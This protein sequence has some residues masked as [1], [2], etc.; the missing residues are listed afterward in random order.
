M[1][2]AAVFVLTGA[3][4]EFTALFAFAGAVAFASVD[5]FATAGFEFVFAG[6]SMAGAS[7][8]AER[9]DVFP[10]TAGI[11]ISRA[12]RKNAVAAAIVNFDKTV[13]VP[14]GPKAALEILLVKSAP[15]SVLPGC[16]NTVATRTMQERK[17]IPYKI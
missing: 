8:F 14:R 6:V 16:S 7:G 2:F 11:E 13:A 9:T 17:K 1:L 4:A 15:A 3:V 12:D 10:V 5:V